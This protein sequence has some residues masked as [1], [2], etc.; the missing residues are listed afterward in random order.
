MV[1]A[2]LVVTG[3]PAAAGAAHAKQVGVLRVRY[4]VLLRADL[5]HPGGGVADGS[6]DDQPAHLAHEVVVWSVPAVP[7][8]LLTISGEGVRDAGIRERVQGPIHG[9][10]PDGIT[11]RAQVSVD[12]ERAH[13]SLPALH[14]G[15]ND[16]ALHGGRQA[17]GTEF[18]GG[19]VS[20][21]H[22]KRISENE[23]YVQ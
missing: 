3:V 9:G 13:R 1:A 23:N 16:P 20:G 7:I 22:P 6:F 4:E 15:Q 8:R 19:P 18:V 11:L 14:G 17:G 21:S 10:Q 12:L 2:D 5:L